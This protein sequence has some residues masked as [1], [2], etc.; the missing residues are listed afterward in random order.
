[1]MCVGFIFIILQGSPNK[2]IQDSINIQNAMATCSQNG[3]CLQSVTRTGFS[4]Y[5]FRCGL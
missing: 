2:T 5:V 1:M 4:S 3:K